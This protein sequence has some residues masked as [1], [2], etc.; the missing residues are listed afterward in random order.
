MLFEFVDYRKYILSY[1]EK[2]PKRGH[3]FRT[4]MA[5][6]LKCKTSFVTQVLNGEQDFNLEQ[7]HA[8]NEL[9]HHGEYESRYF[10]ILIQLARAG[11]K[12]LR[13]YFKKEAEQVRGEALRLKN[14]FKTD[15]I[16]NKVDEFKYFSHADYA[17]VHVLTTIPKYQSKEALI[18]KLKISSKRLDQVLGYLMELGFV[19]YKD[20]KYLPG[21]SIIHLPDDSSIIGTHHTNWRVQAIKA[22]QSPAE[23]DMHYSSVISIAEKD[24]EKI[25][26]IL[27]EALEKARQ[28][29]NASDCEKPFSFCLDF[30]ELN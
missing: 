3:G 15:S 29:I 11:N 25:R 4:Q 5:T 28:V 9:F 22:C 6:A 24:V 27:I 13:D 20:G 2:M 21:P 17:Y 30:Y 23:K 26:S 7:A 14:R 12:S 8:L 19:I 10:L 16:Q 1:I 18:E